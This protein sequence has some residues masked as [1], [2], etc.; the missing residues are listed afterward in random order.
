MANESKYEERFCQMLID[1]M[2]KGKSFE[3]FAAVAKVGRR[4]LFDWLEV[5][6]KWKE[7]KDQAEM[8]ALDFFETRLIAGISGQSVQN[9]DHKKSNPTLLIFALK[10]RFHK[11]YGEN[12]IELDDDD[13]L[14]FTR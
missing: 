6:P 3:S 11:Q 5:H 9:F 10:T 7:A 1:H 4:T 12:K 2:S 14:E 8:A 13:D